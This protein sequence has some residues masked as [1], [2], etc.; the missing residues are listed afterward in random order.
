M[1]TLRK[2][3]RS[4]AIIY[5]FECESKPY[6][7]PPYVSVFAQV[8]KFSKKKKKNKTTTKNNRQTNIVNQRYRLLAFDLNK[9][10]N[11]L[12]IKDNGL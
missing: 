4:R 11:Q 12:S 8:V 6:F 10:H 1:V 9:A 5:L 3:K 7:L 2:P